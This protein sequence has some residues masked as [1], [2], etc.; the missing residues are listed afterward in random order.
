MLDDESHVRAT[1][2]Q[3][4]A[5]GKNILILGEFLEHVLIL[6]VYLLLILEREQKGAVDYLLE[7]KDFLVVLATERVGKV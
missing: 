4:P 2:H 5:Q 1:L 3:F 7:K 6:V